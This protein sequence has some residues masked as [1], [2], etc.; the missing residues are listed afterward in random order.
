[1]HTAD[2]QSLLVWTAP[3]HRVPNLGLSQPKLG[4]VHDRL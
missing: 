2:I 4:A 1:V 3:R